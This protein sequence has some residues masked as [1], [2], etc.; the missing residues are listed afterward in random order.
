[1]GF[2]KLSNMPSPPKLRV[3][4]VQNLK[5]G[6]NIHDLAWQIRA[7]QSPEMRNM[8]WRDGVLQSRPELAV[9]NNGFIRDK[10]DTTSHNHATLAGYGYPYHGWF[11]AV[12][13]TTK[14]IRAMA[15][16]NRDIC[17]DVGA[18]GGGSFVMTSAATAGTFFVHNDV[19]YYK[20]PG[21]FVKITVSETPA[22]GANAYL[23]QAENV[24]GYIPTTYINAKPN[25]SADGSSSGSGFGGGD[26]YQPVNRLSPWRSITYSVST[27][28]AAK[29]IFVPEMAIN[30]TPAS[31][32][33]DDFSVGYEYIQLEYLGADGSW[34]KLDIPWVYYSYNRTWIYYGRGAPSS[35]PT[36]LHDALE[37]EGT[38]NTPNNVR[39]TYRVADDGGLSRSVMDCGIA[40]VY[41][42]GAGLCVVMAGCQAQPNAYFWSG[43]TNVAMDPTYFPVEH[44]NIAGDISDPIVAFGKQQNMLVIFQKRQIGR[45]AFS[46]TTIDGRV[47]ITM[48]YTVV[49]PMLGCDVPNSV[50]L[51]ENNLVFA[52]T[53]TG[54]M[55]IKDTSSAYENNVVNISQNIEAPRTSFGILY[56]LATGFASSIDDGKRYWLCAN[57]NVWLWDY[58]LGGTINDP[59]SLSWF[60]FDTVTRPVCWLGLDREIPRYIGADGYLRE[61]RKV[62]LSELSDELFGECGE[63]ATWDFNPETGTLCI[64][65]SGAM[66]DYGAAP[67][68]RPPWYPLH[69]DVKQLYIADGITH[70]GEYA[71]TDFINLTYL[72]FC[73]VDMG[74]YSFLSLPADV[75]QVVTTLARVTV[76]DAAMEQNPGGAAEILEF[77]RILSGMEFITYGADSV[78]LPTK[79]KGLENKWEVKSEGFEK[80]LTLPIQDFSTYEV[81]KNVEKVIFVTK[82]SGDSTTNIEY[83]TD[84]DLR[85]DLTPL[86][87]YGTTVWVPRDLTQGRRLKFLRFALTAVR[88]PRCLHVRHFC[89]RLRNA[90]RNED[91]AFVSAQ[92]YYTLQGVDR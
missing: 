32:D 49:N 21:E 79:P 51:I 62:D 14:R 42:G 35:E 24:E 66:W 64:R 38:L 84:Y 37:N 69:L 82:S 81:L 63:S 25:N 40:E 73:T 17:V 6:L 46:T 41:G 30:E 85:T 19:L 44:Y 33:A 60:H 90:N 76:R 77:F 74:T 13:P 58:S 68:D 9:Y 7:D 59:K 57:N 2:V 16:A 70:I 91:F 20:Q 83:E 27:E 86:T 39:V 56:D 3:S 65:G 5:G 36:A 12:N 80:L 22:D 15:E 75:G 47:F 89:I 18:V 71:F 78:P 72:Y 92:I 10:E 48:D 67:E 55:F 43:N 11:V 23:L 88:K 61:F 87:T 52:N 34:K 4:T 45:C 50:Q 1:M 31:A 26:A 53:K 54:V 8:W 29:S 28:A